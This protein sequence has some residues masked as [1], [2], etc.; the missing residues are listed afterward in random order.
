MVAGYTKLSQREERS[1]LN[2]IGGVVC[3]SRLL[4]SRIERKVFVTALSEIEIIHS[5]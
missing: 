1:V 5:S 2:C 4:I 3:E